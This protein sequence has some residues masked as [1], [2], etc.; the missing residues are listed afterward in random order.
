MEAGGGRWAMASD[1]RPRGHGGLGTIAGEG[2][3]TPGAVTGRQ[4]VNHE[5]GE[6]IVR[7]K[8][9][10]VARYTGRCRPE[11]PVPAADTHPQPD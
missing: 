4:E 5:A 10:M 9:E 6:V 2:T 8:G 1:C 7:I 11:P 3:Y